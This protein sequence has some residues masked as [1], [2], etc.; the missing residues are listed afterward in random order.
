ML[1]LA[2][3]TLAD[4]APGQCKKACKVD[5]SLVEEQADDVAPRRKL[6]LLLFDTVLAGELS[7]ADGWK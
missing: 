7:R 3:V 1:S 6:A 4:P 5:V 2:P